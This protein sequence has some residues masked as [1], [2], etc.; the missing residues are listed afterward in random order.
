[1][2]SSATDAPSIESETADLSP[3][4]TL[5]IAPYHFADRVSEVTSL[6]IALELSESARRFSRRLFSCLKT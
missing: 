3:V 6:K 1:M 4:E 5:H 2:I